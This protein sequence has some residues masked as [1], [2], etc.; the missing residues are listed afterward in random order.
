MTRVL[1][2]D[3]WRG[4]VIYQIYP[5]SFQDTN[6]DGIGDLKGIIQRLDYIASLGVDAIWI[7]PFFKSPMKDFGYDVS[8]Y[9]DI[10]PIF[11]SLDDFDEMLTKAHNLGLKIIIDLVLSHSSDQHPWFIKSR[12]D[13]HNDRADWYVWADPKIIDGENHPPNNW[14][15]VFGGS[16][17]EYDEKRKQYY[18]H[19]FLKEQPDLNFH[20]KD[21]Q[22]EM[23]DICRFWLDRGVD[24]FRLDVVN[25]YFHD[26]ELRNNPERTSGASYATQFE[27]DVPYSRQ[28]HIYDKSQPENVEFIEEIRALTDQYEA[29]MLV[30]EIGDDQP[31][32]RS[33]EYTCGNKRLHT[34]YNTH[35]MSGTHKTLK[36]NMIIDPVESY[37]GHTGQS[38]LNFEE[39][40]WPSW[41][42][43]NHDV[44]RVASRWFKPYEH[45]PDFSKMLIALL[46]C[47][48]GTVFLYQGEELGLPEAQIAFEDLQDPWAKET[49]PEWQGR[50]G[51]RTPMPW[52]NLSDQNLYA[53]FSQKQPWLPLAESH[54]GLN[55]ETQSTTPDSVLNFTRMFLKWRTNQPTLIRGAYKFYDKDREELIVLKRKY[56][57]NETFCTFNISDRNQHYND[58]EFKRFEFKISGFNFKE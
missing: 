53:G 44:V 29:R 4:A 33:Q 58:L 54:L 11:G 42:F 7:S 34:C 26:R 6:N 5:R 1:D 9:R 14:V 15:S 10:D 39:T 31:I 17:W 46:G 57:K 24:G 27:A 30:G 56:N 16:A 32:K 28:Q 21:V 48:P 55:M 51:C 37:L 22:K 19:N 40:G 41:A 45:D 8:D 35:M 25:F 23:L 2:E 38:E 3:W 20:N 12:T 36:S 49:W 47:L 13:K 18:L 50:D 52:S 43:S